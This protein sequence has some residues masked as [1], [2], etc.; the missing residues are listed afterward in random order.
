MIRLSGTFVAGALHGVARDRHDD[1]DGRCRVLFEGYVANHAE[2]QRTLGLP[3]SATDAGLVAAAFRRWG[4]AMPGRVF[5]EWAAAIADEADGTLLLATDVLGLVAMFHAT[6]ADGIRFSTELGDFDDGRAIDDAAVLRFAAG[7]DARGKGTL[8]SGVNRVGQGRATRI[9]R[10]ICSFA[11]HD[12]ASIAPLALA[13]PADYE[14]R[15]REVVTDAVRTALP[16]AG[17]TWCELSGGLDSSTVVAVAA[18]VLN[19]PIAAL[20]YVF[21]ASVEAE[22]SDWMRPVVEAFDLPWHRLDADLT[23]AFSSVPT[24]SRTGPTGAMLTADFFRARSDILARH[25]VGTVLT[26]MCGDAVLIG[27]VPEPF[28]LADLRDPRRLWSE[29]RAW[30]RD[31]GGARPTSFWLLR[32]AVRPWL[33]R[34]GSPRDRPLAPW[35]AAPH[36]EYCR[37]ARAASRSPPGLTAGDAYYW[38]RV[39]RGAAIAREGQETGGADFRNPLLY[40]PL[41]EF[42]AAVPWPIKLRPGLDRVLQRRALR[43]I[44]PEVTRRRRDKRGP[45]HAIF[46]GLAASAEWSRLLT[47]APALVERGYFDGDEWRKAVRLAQRGFCASSLDFLRACM[48]EAWLSA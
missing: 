23:P 30:A 31:G 42:M 12:P 34:G 38:D 44:L 36:R 39:L 19:A 41:V 32:Y 29:A 27:D 9:D 11:V 15:F 1:S 10:G 2:L 46:A 33:G 7:L 26:G 48:L 47:H 25:G 21:G 3:N 28:Y 24:A 35:I 18:G 40:L 6:T 20:S 17:A 13:D 43:G 37:A 22:E 16:A 14:A 4:P 5:G 45:G 8:L